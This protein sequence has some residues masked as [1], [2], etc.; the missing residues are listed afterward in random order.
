MLLPSGVG[1]GP[2]HSLIFPEAWQHAQATCR[3]TSTRFNPG[4][5]KELHVLLHR[6]TMF[7]T[8]TH[9]KEAS[10]AFAISCNLSADIDPNIYTM[11]IVYIY[12]YPIGFCVHHAFHITV[13]LY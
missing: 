8:I 10:E 2:I 5:L 9:G 11:S 3:C 1:K 4:K 6:L 12:I 13:L 7:D